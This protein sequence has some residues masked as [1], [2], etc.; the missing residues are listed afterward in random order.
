MHEHSKDKPFSDE[1]A[2]FGAGVQCRLVHF[3]VELSLG[4][5]AGSFF[6]GNA[7]D[8]PLGSGSVLHQGDPG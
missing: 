2:P 3:P 7:P 5:F 6:S 1:Q 4:I 8:E